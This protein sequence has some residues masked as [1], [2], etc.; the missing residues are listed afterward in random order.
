MYSIP[1]QKHIE[2][3]QIL[4]RYDFWCY[5]IC[6]S[7]YNS[8]RYCGRISIKHDNENHDISTANIAFSE[9]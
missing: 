6:R 1:F 7:I 2:P 8:D 4:V 5:T 9:H 3:A